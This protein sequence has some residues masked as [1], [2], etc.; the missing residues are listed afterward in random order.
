MS[1]FEFMSR[2]TIGQYVP[3]GSPVHHVDARVRVLGLTLLLLAVVITPSWYGVLGGIGLTI[4]LLAASRINLR[5]ALSGLIGPLPFL[6][7]IALLQ[8]LFNIQADAG[9]VHLTLGRFVI[10][11]SDLMIGLLV[12]LRFCAL[13]LILSL[14]SFVISTSEMILGIQWL[15]SPLTWVR[16]SPHA[17]ILMLQIALRFLPLLAQ[18]TER[19]AKA[20]AAR[21]VEWGG[22]KGGPLARARQLIPLIVPLFISSLRRA[23][24]FALA[25]EARGYNADAKRTSMIE[26]RFRWLDGLAMLLMVSASAL[27]LFL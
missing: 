15:L 26:M 6:I 25:M 21:G 5:Y 22:R 9:E 18:T 27:I 19:I 13:I 16:I 17:L 8:M 12:V 4:I 24:Y 14:G 7:F 23:E 11:D 3:T 20:Q 1:D 10:A 2:V